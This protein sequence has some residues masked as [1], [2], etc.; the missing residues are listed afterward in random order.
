M[1]FLQRTRK[2]VREEI[3]KGMSPKAEI[4][5]ELEDLSEYCASVSDEDMVVTFIFVEKE[6]H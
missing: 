5:E 6:E 1:F 4:K 2:K 3:I